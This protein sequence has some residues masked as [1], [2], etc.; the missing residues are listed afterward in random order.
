MTTAVVTAWYEHRELAP[1]YF[2]A[3]QHADELIIID[4]GSDPP[5]DFADVRIEVNTGFCFANNLGLEQATADVVVFLNNDVKGGR[6]NWI[7][8]LAAETGP[9]KLAGACL[10]Y[11][12][13]TDID[14]QTLPYLDGWCIAGRRQDLLALG[15]FD[16]T[17]EEPAYYS[18]NLLCLEARAQGFELIE[19]PTGL[20]HLENV[21]ANDRDDV[22]A[23]SSANRARYQQRARELLRVAA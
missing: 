4:N 1:A 2:A 6:A 8:T 11:D 3:V 21:T 16:D 12:R 9:K 7:Q 5:L 13:H 19:V 15:G 20:V 17:L 14:G 23:A 10:R 22:K 18:D